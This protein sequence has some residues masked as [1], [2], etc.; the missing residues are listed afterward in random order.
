MARNRDK[1]VYREPILEQK[2]IKIVEETKTEEPVEKPADA[3]V[4][5]VDV[6]L[7]IR[8]EPEVIANNQIAILG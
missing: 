8:K 4:Y 6:A 5:G 3:I 7:N 2:S 1:A